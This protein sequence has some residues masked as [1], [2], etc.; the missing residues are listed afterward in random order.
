MIRA[1]WLIGRGHDLLRI[2]EV[3]AAQN[4]IAAGSCAPAQGLTFVNVRLSRGRF[5]TVVAGL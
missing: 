2:D 1:R 4:R 3:P 5:A